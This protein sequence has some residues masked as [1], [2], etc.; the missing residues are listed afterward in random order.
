LKYLFVN[1]AEQSWGAEESMVALAKS[2]LELG[3]E[4]RLDCFSDPV[5]KLWRIEVNSNVRRVDISG[6]QWS[7]VRKCFSLLFKTLPSDTPRVVIIFSHYLYPKV[8]FEKAKKIMRLS[9]AREDIIWAID[10]HD[11]F[12]SLLGVLNFK[13]FTRFADRIIA[14]SHFTARQ[15]HRSSLSKVLVLYRGVELDYNSQDLSSVKASS[16]KKSGH[17]VGIV[18]R[19]DPEKNHLMVAKAILKSQSNPFLVV[20]GAGSSGYLNYADALLDNLG[21]TLGNRLIFE[22]KVSR[23]KA[24]DNLDLLVVGNASEPMGRTVLEA[25]SKGVLA[26]VPDRGGASELVEDRL[27]GLK[28]KA[29]NPDSLAEVIDF[30][31]E[32]DELLRLMTLRAQAE[33]QMESMLSTYGEN[34]HN[35]VFSKEFMVALQENLHTKHKRSN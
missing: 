34:V 4:V 35:F 5:E 24:L 18:G 26:V 28:Y 30:A 6:K 16:T 10:V 29:D 32:N 8:I 1:G 22:G 31:F 13:F 33:L 2:L 19:L 27:N 12:K 21:S 25:M 20:R 17:R 11:N 15:L 14:V 9:R 23:D 7:N 3:H